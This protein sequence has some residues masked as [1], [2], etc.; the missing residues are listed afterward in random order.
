MNQ[1]SKLPPTHQ[2]NVVIDGKQYAVSFKE[3]KP[4][5]EHTDN[6]TDYIKLALWITVAFAFVTLLGI[7]FKVLIPPYDSSALNR[8]ALPVNRY[9]P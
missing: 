2:E 4:G 5:K 3:V 6:D 1:Q 7:W 9:Q 8:Q